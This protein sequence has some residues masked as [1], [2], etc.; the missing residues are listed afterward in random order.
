MVPKA[1]SVQAVRLAEDIFRVSFGAEAEREDLLL[2]RYGFVHEE[3]PERRTASEAEGLAASGTPEGTRLRLA[4]RDGKPLLEGIVARAADGG[5]EALFDL[6]ATESLYGLGDLLRGTLDRRGC[7]A[8][9]WVRNVVS[10]LPVPFLMSS[11]GYGIFLNTTLRHYW[12]VGAGRPDRLRVVLPG[13]PLEF[14]LFRGESLKEVLAAYTRVTGRP[15]LP[16]KWS[17]GLWYLCHSD[18][19]QFEVIHTARSFRDRGVPCDVIGLEPGWMETLYD[20]SVEKQWD[21]K[22]FYRPRT[23]MVP[24]LKR[25]GFKLELWLCNDYD[26]SHEEERRSGRPRPAQPSRPEGFVNE[27]VERDPRL[28]KVVRFD[29]VTRPEEPWFEHLK[30]FVDDGADLFKQ[31]AANQVR[32]HPDRLC[33]NGRTDREM[34]NLYPL[35]YSRQMYEGF[36][37][38]TGRRPCG[39]TASGWA[40][41]QRYT[42]SW[43]GDT[44]GGPATLS[45]CLNLAL[46]GHT[47]TTCDMDVTTKEGIHYGFLLPWATVNSFAYFRQPWLLGAELEEVFRDYARLRIRL[48]PYL[49]THARAA[50]VTGVPFLMPLALE[51]PNDPACRSARGQYLLGRELMVAAFA[52]RVVLPAGRWCDLWSGQV[53][54]GPGEVECAW[55][56]NRGG[57]LFLRENSLLPWGPCVNYVGEPSAEGY[58]LET[59]L[60]KDGVAEFDLY[61]DDGVSFAYEQGAY[62]LHKLRAEMSEG[63]LRIQA[64]AGLLI[65]GVTAHVEAY[66]ERMEVNGERVP[67]EWINAADGREAKAV[68]LRRR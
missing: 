29:A 20:Y 30:K 28:A 42:G 7:R 10:Y 12:D 17:F 3:W 49:Y 43:A 38:H 63:V 48:T 11:R 2:S 35:M 47:L 31:D 58:T 8:D 46:S 54:N 22:R 60:R 1:T 62:T 56:S 67:F 5:W 55:P 15:C 66:P 39:F 51:Y 59:H 6:D 33:G 21:A 16:P 40:G 14:F 52:R 45:A 32:E 4:R 34:H 36:R 64:P 26:L 25:M 68:Y 41:V 37:A 23:G 9:M 24:A 44:G 65:E 53:F 19:D 61:E 50:H 18:A 13:G 57:G 27:D